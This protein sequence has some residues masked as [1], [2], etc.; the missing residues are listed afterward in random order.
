MFRARDE[1]RG[2]LCVARSL[3]RFE[4]WSPLSRGRPDG[5]RAKNRTSFILFERT[6][7]PDT[8]N[9]ENINRVSNNRLRNLYKGIPIVIAMFDAKK[10]NMVLSYLSIYDHQIILFHLIS[11]VCNEFEFLIS[12]DFLS[13]FFFFS[14]WKIHANPRQLRKERDKEGKIF[15]GKYGWQAGSKGWM[16]KL[17]RCYFIRGKEDR[18]ISRWT[19]LV[20]ENRIPRIV[21]DEK[22]GRR[23]TDIDKGGLA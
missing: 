22:F 6:A 23:F 21:A 16:G 2:M 18:R 13:F 14:E 1:D 15:R 17:A 10:S 19:A 5:E 8:W 7:I 3:E 20:E 4:H 11:S 12:C 9:D